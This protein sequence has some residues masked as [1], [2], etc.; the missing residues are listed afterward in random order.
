MNTPSLPR[1]AAPSPDLATTV[2]FTRMVQAALSDST[3]RRY[4]TSVDVIEF[5]GSLVV[6]FVAAYANAQWDEGD[7]FLEET[8]EFFA[9]AAK[10]SWWP[11]EEER[12]RRAD[13]DYLVALARRVGSAQV[14]NDEAA[15]AQAE[16]DD[17]VLDAAGKRIAAALREAGLVCSDWGDG[18]VNVRGWPGDND[19]RVC[20]G[21]THDPDGDHTLVDIVEVDP[22]GDYEYLVETLPVEDLDLVV[23][24]VRAVLATVG[25]AA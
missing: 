16:R 3:V 15:I 24:Q 18:I 12:S 4:P 1:W 17:A 8:E 5:V 22:D 19:L 6:E 7:D 25:G 9:A 20:A 13:L 21:I 14:L 10:P 23:E 2:E 11:T